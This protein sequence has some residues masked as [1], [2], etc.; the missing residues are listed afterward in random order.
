M[1]AAIEPW[2]AG[3][4]IRDLRD[5]VLIRRGF[6]SRE[7]ADRWSSATDRADLRVFFYPSAI[8]WGEDYDERRG[9]KRI[10]ARSAEEALLWATTRQ[11]ATLTIANIFS[12]DD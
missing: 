5:G 6:A 1:F 7:E 10:F 3:W 11:G 2:G 12:S 8:L 9:M 4:A